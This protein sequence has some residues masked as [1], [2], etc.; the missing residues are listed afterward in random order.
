[1]IQPVGDDVRE[2]EREI[3]HGGTGTSDSR[4]GCGQRKRA[5]ACPPSSHSVAPSASSPFFTINA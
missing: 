2:P 4:R 5:L 3:P 1:V